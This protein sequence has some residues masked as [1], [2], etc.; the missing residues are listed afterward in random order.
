MAYGHVDGNGLI[1]NA[2]IA[3]SLETATEVAPGG[4]TAVE[5]PDGVGIGWRLD[6]DTGTFHA[7][8]AHVPEESA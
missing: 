7:P 4:Y 2:L 8:Q 3:D 1:V 6:L 5:L